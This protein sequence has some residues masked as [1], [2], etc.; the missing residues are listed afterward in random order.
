ML[1]QR[2]Q[3]PIDKKLFALNVSIYIAAPLFPSVWRHFALAFPLFLSFSFQFWVYRTVRTTTLNF[4]LAPL[5]YSTGF[6]PFLQLLSCSLISSASLMSS[7][8]I[9]KLETSNLFLRPLPDLVTDLPEQELLSIYHSL[10][11]DDHRFEAGF[12]C[13]ST[14]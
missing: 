10:G 6:L 14:F 2:K 1:L 12:A 11:Y 9:L 4:L 7:C 5:L 8:T 13:T 3:G